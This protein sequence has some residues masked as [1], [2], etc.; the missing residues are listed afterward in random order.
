MKRFM[1]MLLA[2]FGV[3]ALMLA[4]CESTT[5]TVDMDGDDDTTMTDDGDADDMMD[6]TDTEEMEDAE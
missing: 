6:S 2:S 1:Q 3:M 5:D 4:G